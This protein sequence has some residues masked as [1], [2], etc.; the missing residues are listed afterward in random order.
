MRLSSHW[1]WLLSFV[2]LLDSRCVAASTDEAANASAA[3]AAIDF[4]RQIRPILANTC[5]TCHG[6]DEAK[7]EADLR[8]DREASAKEYAIVPGDP[9]GSELL[10]RITSDDPDERMPPAD[11]KQQLSQDQI[12]LLQRWI[13][14]GSP[15]SQHWSYEPPR[16]EP[17]P[18]LKQ[19]SWPA[20]GIDHF[21]LAKL[22]EARLQPTPSA[23]R[24]T[25]IRRVTFDL[26]GL[27]PTI[28]EVD[29]FLTDESS[30]AFEQVV[31]RLLAS[32]RYGEHMALPWLAAARY[33]DTNGYQND[34]T[35]T[36]WPWRDWVIRAMNDNMPFDEFTVNQLAG[37]LL[38]NPTQDQRIATGFHRNHGLN[39][40][41]G[42]HPEESRVE[43]VIDR[44]STT[45][46]VWLGLT[47]GCAR[48][49]DHK[50]D[51][52]SQQ[53]FYQLYAYFN[54]VDEGGGVDAG[55]NARPV[56]SLPTAEQLAEANQLQQKIRELEQ[57]QQ[58]LLP[59]TNIEQLEWAQSTQRWLRL[60]ASDQLWVPQQNN[61]Q[62]QCQHDASIEYLEDG[63][64]LVARMVDSA[65]DYVIRIA[66]PPATHSAL[67]IEA[68]KHPQLLQGL[69]S[70]GVTGGFSVTGLKV[71]LDGEPIKLVSAEANIGSQADI[72]GLLDNSKYTTWSVSKP[73]R[74]P[75]VPTWIGRFEAPLEIREESELVVRMK[76]QSRTGE[77]PI[78]RFRI[79]LTDYLKPTIKPHLG[80][81]EEVVA[82][83]KTPVAQR[84]T[85][86]RQRI[87]R[88]VVNVQRDP[89]QE[90]IDDLKQQI[91]DRQ[92]NYLKTMVMRDRQ[93]PRD[94]YRL[95]RGLWNQPARSKKLQPGVLGCLPSLPADA[96]SNR[97][98]LA[99]WLVRDDHPL[100]ARV[101]VNRYWQH[102]FGTG[103]VK[104]NE[105]FG[106][107]G[108][109]PSHPQL[110]DWLALEFI[111]SGWNVKQMHKLIVMS[112]TYQQ[113][114]RAAQELIERDP[115]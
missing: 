42:R 27:P 22:E 55:G 56:M 31:D 72:D 15:W 96:P 47:V 44:V 14:E 109:R 87:E 94:T 64:V 48:C 86:Q 6:P 61:L 7:R 49:H 51:E 37:D 71:E 101:T 85:A 76:H 84:T 25:L 92:A 81:A 107:Q 18:K 54:S 57:R 95:D 75:P 111:D 67:R 28:A 70:T 32:P 108:E 66:L 40:E 39:G 91:E 12:A 52:I 79:S 8:L 110:L 35:R 99:R 19:Q 69:F 2:G 65:D 59:P 4:D 46:T 102:F 29:D 36:M 83:L 98:A 58:E 112:A 105:D 60:A 73:D 26:T 97:L 30:D 80:L 100:T 63:S 10:R 5:F 1:L 50:Y 88:H 103:L 45:G 13:D 106:V 34:A 114:S 93:Q 89:L 9:G 41:G 43:Y 104:T 68:M 74:A 3:L 78:G 62:L 24:E 115:Y 11:Q 20:V 23:S 113:S 82:A 16:R 53:E 77:A 21:V 17:L 90:K 33:A 38:E